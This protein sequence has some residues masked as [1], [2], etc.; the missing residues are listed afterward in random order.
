M[1][2]AEQVFKL[3]TQN[4]P[5]SASYLLQLATHYYLVKR[6]DDMESV[7][8]KMNDEK[9]FPDGRL[10]AGDFFFFRLRQMTIARV[11]ST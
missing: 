7:I 9:S 2:D 4:N 1:D 8:R 10:L 11:R 3:K 6:P 5:K